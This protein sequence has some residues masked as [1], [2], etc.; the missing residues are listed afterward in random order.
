MSPI[1]MR[2]F[3][4]LIEATRTHI[5]LALDDESL[6]QWLLR[7]ARSERPLNHVETDLLN[8]YIHTR[9]PLIRDLAQEY[10]LSC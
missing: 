7:H 4:S 3:W 9:M 6:A 8:N 5:P 10:Q 1:M 2:Q